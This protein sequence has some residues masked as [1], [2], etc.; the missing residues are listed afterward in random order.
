MAVEKW[1]LEA[2]ADDWLLED[3]TGN[4]ILDERSNTLFIAITRRTAKQ[5]RPKQRMTKPKRG[6]FR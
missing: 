1:E 2:S 3:G 5:M 4:W 6:L